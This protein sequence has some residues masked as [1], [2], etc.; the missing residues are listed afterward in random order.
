MFTLRSS[1]TATLVRGLHFVGKHVLRRTASAFPGAIGLTLDPDILSYCHRGKEIIVVTGTNGKT[2]TTHLLAAMVKAR[3]G[4]VTT[5]DEGAN[6]P[7]GLVTALC[8][9]QGRLAV[10]EVDEGYLPKLLHVLKPR[11]VLIT[12]FA[13]DQIERFD[14]GSRLIMLL[15]ERMQEAY[16]R[17]GTQLLLSQKTEPWQALFNEAPYV[18]RSPVGNIDSVAGWI[19]LQG[20]RYDVPFRRRFELENAELAIRAALA[21][22]IH[23]S[24]IESALKTLTPVEG[25]STFFAYKGLPLTVTL[26]KNKSGFDAL[27]QSLNENDTPDRLLIALNDA[28]SDGVLGSWLWDI[29]YSTLR[30]TAQNRLILSGTRAFELAQAL[31][32]QG[33]P[34]DKIAVEPEPLVALERLF[35]GL[36]PFA[37]SDALEMGQ[38]QADRVCLGE[39]IHLYVNYTALAQYRKYLTTLPMSNTRRVPRPVVVNS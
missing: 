8:R 39:N 28:P 5:N 19:E 4:Y 35:E 6:L 14:D 18:R 26:V 33:V 32:V 2:T 30:T 9:G 23:P 31:L 12:N 16:E 22:N 27:F 1:A 10:L 3:D 17:Y 24:Q 7:A 20:V 11:F 15:K 37:G 13:P 36:T 34:R 38:V 25:R 29:D 21:L